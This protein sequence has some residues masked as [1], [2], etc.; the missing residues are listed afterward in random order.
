MSKLN[1]GIFC[2]ILVIIFSCKAEETKQFKLL[3]NVFDSLEKDYLV[4]LVEYKNKEIGVIKTAIPFEGELLTFSNFDIIKPKHYLKIETQDIKKLIHKKDL[5]PIELI[6]YSD[7]DN[8]KKILD[9]KKLSTI[10]LFSDF[11]SDGN[12]NYYITVYSFDGNGLHSIF[13]TTEIE[14]TLISK[15]HLSNAF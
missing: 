10:L 5:I 13:K 4:K 11:R 7:L 2:A 15:M 8:I 3:E 12:S 6:E 1:L 9:E 14:N